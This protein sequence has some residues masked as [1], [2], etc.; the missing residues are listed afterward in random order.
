MMAYLNPPGRS[1]PLTSLAAR[2]SVSDTA[3]NERRH[4]C[5]GILASL[6]DVPLIVLL[7]SVPAAP[8]AQEYSY[9]PKSLNSDSAD[10]AAFSFAPPIEHQSHSTPVVTY[11]SDAAKYLCGYEVQYDDTYEGDTFG[12]GHS[13]S[14]EY[15]PE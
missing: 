14:Q 9:A 10:Y 1:A 3:E 13:A 6:P 8:V 12:Y 11:S 5:V 15:K 2:R 7:E 4:S